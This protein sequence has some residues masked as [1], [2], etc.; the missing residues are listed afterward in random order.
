M[1]VFATRQ[2]LIDVIRELVGIKSGL[3]VLQEDLIG[4]LRDSQ[5]GVDNI[6]LVVG[7]A[8]RWWDGELDAMVTVR[9]EEL[10]ANF[11]LA[12]HGFGAL[13]DTRPPLKFL[14]DFRHGSF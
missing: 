8:T 10:E 5:S 11:V 4:L 6:T 2:S 7:G 14:V 12:M 1:R 13:P 3:L 9:A